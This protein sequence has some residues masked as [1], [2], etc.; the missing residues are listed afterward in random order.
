LEDLVQNIFRSKLLN[1]QM[2]QLFWRAPPL[3]EQGASERW[4]FEAADGV[5][6]FIL[7]VRV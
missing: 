6:F 4:F 3:F 2:R 5:L 1:I 7:G